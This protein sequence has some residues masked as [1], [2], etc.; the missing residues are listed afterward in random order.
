VNLFEIRSAIQSATDAQITDAAFVWERICRFIAAAGE[1]DPPGSIG[2]TFGRRSR[3]SFGPIILSSLL[4][5]LHTSAAPALVRLFKEVDQLLDSLE[6]GR[7]DGRW[8]GQHGFTEY[9]ETIDTEI[10][11]FAREAWSELCL[12]VD[13]AP[14][15]E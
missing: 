5:A 11:S 2:L 12:A 14:K 13:S 4:V 6:I 8:Q 7:K 10:D 15:A 1:L 3:A 9:L